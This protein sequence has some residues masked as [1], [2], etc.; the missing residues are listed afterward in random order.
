[1]NQ[2]L[3]V[4]ARPSSWTRGGGDA[5]HCWSGWFAS[6][7]T[8][9]AATPPRISS[10]APSRSGAA[11][12]ARN[13]LDTATLCVVRS[14]RAPS[15]HAACRRTASRTAGSALEPRRRRTS[16]A[17]LNCVVVDYQG[18]GREQPQ[19]DDQEHGGRTMHSRAPRHA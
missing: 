3:A 4:V 5:A 6:L 12:I 18:G 9:R 2:P 19:G 10:P 15:S 7:T 1:A 11:A 8:A 14:I 16:Y 17:A 13:P